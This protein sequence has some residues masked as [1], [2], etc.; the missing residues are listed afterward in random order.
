MYDV[1]TVGSS[2]VDVFASTEFMEEI[3]IKDKDEVKNLMAYPIG[4]KIL[5][6]ELNFT[7]GGG[8]T[9]TAVALSRLGNKVAW[10]GVL[11][12]DE[13]ADFITRHLKTEKIDILAHKR[14]GISGYSVILDSLEH[15]RTILAFKGVNNSFDYDRLVKNKLKTKWFYFCSMVDN[16]YK[17]LVKLAKFAE[18]ENIKT[19]FNA[20]E[21]LVK[22]GSNHLKEILE[23][24]EIFVLNYEEAGYLIPSQD[25]KDRLKGIHRLG[26]RI[27][28]I[29]DGHKDVSCYDGK[30]LYKGK[31][32]DLKPV[33]TTGAGDAFASSF[34]AGIIKKGDVEFAIK[35]GVTNAESVISHHGA[36]NNLLKWSEALKRLKKNP[37]K[38]IRKK[39]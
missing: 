35:L 9:N 6:K 10:V 34:L 20:S 33:E 22:K 31:N 27:V 26:P 19:V 17:S 32:H 3:K 4:S 5:V 11:G 14:K 25:I 30:Y 18:K 8:G 29:T 1:I 37:V 12:D 2:T 38:V 13:N 16:A 7:T 39:I 15:D 36:K 24:T 28:V 23:R 21:Y